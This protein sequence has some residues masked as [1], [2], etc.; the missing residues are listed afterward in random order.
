[1]NIMAACNSQAYQCVN[2]VRARVG[3]GGLKTG[4]TQEQFREAVLRE[5]ACEFGYEEVRFF[6]LIRWKMEIELIKL[7]IWLKCI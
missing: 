5:R 1:M 2:E 4:M 7:S 3:L 6:D